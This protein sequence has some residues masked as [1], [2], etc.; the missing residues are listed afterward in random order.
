MFSVENTRNGRTCLEIKRTEHT[1]LTTSQ[2]EN[3]SR[4]IGEIQIF[5]ILELTSVRS[6]TYHGSSHRHASGLDQRWQKQIPRQRHSSALHFACGRWHRLQPVFL[7]RSVTSRTSL[8][9]C[10]IIWM[11][12]ANLEPK[13]KTADYM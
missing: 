5:D 1:V 3:D 6:I 4:K 9:R 8:T 11:M 2:S 12:T 7:P 13:S 10:E